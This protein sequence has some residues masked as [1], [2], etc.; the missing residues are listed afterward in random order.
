MQRLIDEL[1]I[2]WTVTNS[3]EVLVSDAILGSGGFS[4]V[5][6][7]KFENKISAVKRFH[8]PT[9][10]SDPEA[11][12]RRVRDLVAAFKHEVTT[13]MALAF[14]GGRSIP[15]HEG[16]VVGF[17][18]ACRSPPLIVYELL[19][20]TLRAMVYQFK[21]FTAFGDQVK[22]LT[23]IA[24]SVNYLHSARVPHLDIKLDNILLNKRDPSER[25]RDFDYDVKLADLS[26]VA[27]CVNFTTLSPVYLAF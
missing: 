17:R 14:P 19:P 24:N 20:L 22:L 16:Y 3:R 15:W 12:L 27:W 26:H 9:V 21:R 10:S 2:D 7:G 11:D 1:A 5:Y 13:M 6:K 25:K 4:T 23:I 18:G 8:T